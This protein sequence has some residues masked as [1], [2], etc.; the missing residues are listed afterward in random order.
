MEDV[1]QLHL[2]KADVTVEN[3]HIS[4]LI[5][6]SLKTMHKKEC[7]KVCNRTSINVH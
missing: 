3:C 6:L 4:F 7:M 2:Q 1:M 5:Y